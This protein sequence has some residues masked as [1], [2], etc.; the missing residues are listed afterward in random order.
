MNSHKKLSLLSLAISAVMICGSAVAGTASGTLTADATLT[1]ACE[2]SPTSQIHFGSFDALA[3]TGNKDANSGSSFQV[4]CTTGLSPEIYAAASRSMSNG[5]DSLPFN[6]SL[7]SGGADDLASAAVSAQA[8]SITQDG[9]MQDVT[10]YGRV[11]A[12]NFASLSAG[13][14]SGDVSVSVVY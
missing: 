9:T 11:L 14:Y 6:L 10:L 4:A 5:T 3:S 13:D 7:T 8:I 2:V 1:S 12:S